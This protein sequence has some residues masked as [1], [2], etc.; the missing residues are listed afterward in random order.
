MNKRPLFFLLVLSI[1]AGCAPVI[2]RETLQTVDRAITFKAVMDEP[3]GFIDATVLFGGAII[4]IEN[5]G[6]STVIEVM[7]QPLNRRLRPVKPGESAGRFLAVFN[8]FKDPAIYL[9]GRFLTIAGKV[10]APHI[11]NIGKMPYRYPVIETIDHHLW[12]TP[13]YTG[14]AFGIGLGFGIVEGR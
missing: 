14:P 5:Q 4:S 9:P 8:G 2:P 10:K 11:Q 7:Q 6:G 13:E 3:E 12:S 1:L